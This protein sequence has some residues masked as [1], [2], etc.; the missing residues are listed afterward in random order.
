VSI[1]VVDDFEPIDIEIHDRDAALSCKHEKAR[2]SSGVLVVNP[3]V[4]ADNYVGIERI[5]LDAAA[6]AAR[7]SPRR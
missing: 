3:L 4:A 2:F 5:D 7:C 1:S 6:D